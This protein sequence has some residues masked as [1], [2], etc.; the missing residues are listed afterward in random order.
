MVYSVWETAV[1]YC[2]SHYEI[3]RRH[4]PGPIRRGHAERGTYRPILPSLK[5]LLP[6]LLVVVLR[7]PRVVA[8]GMPLAIAMLQERPKGAGGGGGI[9]LCTYSCCHLPNP[10]SST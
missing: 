8:L 6:E 2:K 7:Q 1:C 3:Y 10:P 4:P 5:A 9:G